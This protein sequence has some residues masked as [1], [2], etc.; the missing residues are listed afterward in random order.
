MACHMIDKRKYGP[1]FSEVAA[2]YTGDLTAID[3][4]AAKI[5]EGG[6]GIWGG[7]DVMPPQPMVTDADA[8]SMAQLIM[9]LKP[10]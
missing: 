8:K 10:V 2:R 3:K 9:S 5:K 4:L 6:T 1:P 7:E